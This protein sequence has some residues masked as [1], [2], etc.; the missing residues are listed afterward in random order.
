MDI[1][2]SSF[3]LLFLSVSVYGLFTENGYENKREEDITDSVGA[4][5]CMY[6]IGET[7]EVG[8]YV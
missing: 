6:C 5:L 8:R 2:L 4:R 1:P 7:Y 3:F